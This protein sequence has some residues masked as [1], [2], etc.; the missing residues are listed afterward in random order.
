MPAASGPCR[1]LYRILVS[2][3]VL[4]FMAFQS[5]EPVGL[6]VRLLRVGESPSV[7]VGSTIVEVLGSEENGLRTVYLNSA[8]VHLS[9]LYAA[10]Q[11]RARPT[12][13]A[14]AH[15]HAEDNVPWADVMNAIDAAKG[16]HAD[17]VLLTSSRARH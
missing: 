9:D 6:D 12:P 3:L 1:K 8:K 10:M 7:P 11:T 17:V 2:L 5:A 14:T 15:L 16:L 4:V 13:D